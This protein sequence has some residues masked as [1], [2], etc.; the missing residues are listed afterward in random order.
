MS[1]LLFKLK[2][3]ALPFTPIL[4]PL[5][6]LFHHPLPSQVLSQVLASCNYKVP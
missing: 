6:I 5:P 1:P 2:F 4:Q 3:V